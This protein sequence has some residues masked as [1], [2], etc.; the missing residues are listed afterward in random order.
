MRRS[1]RAR[2]SHRRRACPPRRCLP[3]RCHGR[4]TRSSS[5][6]NWRETWGKRAAAWPTRGNASTPASTCMRHEGEIVRAVASDKVSAPLASHGF[7]TLSESLCVG[8]FT[9]VHVRVGRERKGQP[10]DEARAPIVRDDAGSPLRVRVRRGTRFELGDAI[11]TANRFNHV[12]LNVGLPG[13]EVNPLLLP[14]VGFVDTVPPTIA[15]RRHHPADRGRRPDR[16]DRQAAR[17]VGTR[18]DRGGRIRSG[19]WQH[20]APPARR[21]PPGL[22][23]AARRWHP[24]PGFEAP[25]VTIDFTRLPQDARAPALVYA[26]G[27]GIPVYGTRRTRFLYTVT[28]TVRDGIAEE[29]LWDTTALERYGRS[30]AYGERCWPGSRDRQAEVALAMWRSRT[31][32][33]LSP[34]VV[35]ALST[36]AAA[37]P[38]PSRP[39]ESTSRSPG[40]RSAAA[41][42]ARGRS[43]SNGFGTC[44]WK[45][46][47][48]AR[49]RSPAVA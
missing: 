23:G 14:L 2:R 7:D 11:G 15:P 49:A 24:A 9:Y 8:P 29:G 5:R 34:L 20:R 41:P 43:G 31:Q 45:P 3:G 4:S 27:S 10:I 26:P 30:A 28:N 37:R 33:I 1:R 21:V 18:A 16:E 48:I 17:R 35:D 38:N 42:C 44:S 13:R 12:H 6:T 25:R 32:R 19:R 40:W 46:E 39:R 22:P 47:L 36:Q